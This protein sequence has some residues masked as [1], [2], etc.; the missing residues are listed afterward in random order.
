MC[1]SVY[2]KDGKRNNLSPSERDRVLENEIIGKCCKSGM[3]CIAYAYKE[4]SVQ[5]LQYL[6]ESN[7]DF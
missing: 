3:R 6:R 7:N 1:T 5:D 4:I 2:S